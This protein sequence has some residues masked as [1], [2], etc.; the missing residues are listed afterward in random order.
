MHQA[1]AAQP[2]DI[3]YSLCQYGMGD[4]WKWGDSVGGQCWRTTGDIID[5]WRSMSGIGFNQDKNAPYAKPGNWNAPDM[6]IVGEVG[7]GNLHP[8][9]LTVDEQYTHISL[10]C[11]LAAPLLIGC[12]MEKF[13][14]F[15]LSLLSNDEVLAV[16]QDELGKQATCVI[17][18]GNV[19][20]YEKEL[21][22]GSRAVGFFNL[23][24][25]TAELQFQDFN[26]LH[27]S[28]KQT[29]RDLWRQ[30]NVATVDTAKDAL[31]LTVPVHG[32]LLYKFTAAK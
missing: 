23:G 30:K 3:V 8:T 22:D 2:R 4:V 5:T 16:D 17:S 18:N 14:D 31:P 27:L 7:W 15:T 20:I 6:L 12:D 11:L 25:R 13:D 10:W 1:L 21:A 29:A 9:R 26:A 32:V 19:R 24:D 28:G